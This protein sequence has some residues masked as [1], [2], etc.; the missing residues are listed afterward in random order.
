MFKFEGVDDLVNVVDDNS[1][2][3]LYSAVDNQ[4]YEI[5]KVLVE[6][7]ADPFHL[8][9]FNISPLVLLMQQNTPTSLSIAEMILYNLTS[10]HKGNTNIMVEPKVDFQFSKITPHLK[11]L[12]MRKEVRLT[13]PFPFC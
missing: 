13:L 5:A 8:T 11:P 9:K 4:H 3:P 2:S 10:E 12:V 1:L 7:K 6:K